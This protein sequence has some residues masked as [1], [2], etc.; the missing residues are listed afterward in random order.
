MRRRTLRRHSESGD[1]QFPDSMHTLHLSPRR[2]VTAPRHRI[3]AWV[4]LSAMLA[5]LFAGSFG[6]LR[7]PPPDEA[8]RA[9]P[10]PLVICTAQGLQSPE[11]PQSPAT[12]PVS[13]NDDLCLLCLPL[14]GYPATMAQSLIPAL[15]AMPQGQSVM[16]ATREAPA[17]P[18]PNS[19]APAVRAPPPDAPAQLFHT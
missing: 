19:V 4:G 7:L 15:L 13:I 6:G 3:A 11:G 12:P 1:Q 8:L 17:R 16:L 2:S 5:V 10:G 14:S 9:P 18:R